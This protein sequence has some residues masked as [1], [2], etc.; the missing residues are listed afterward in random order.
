[1]TF[2]STL[3]NPRKKF[4]SKSDKK[5]S[6]IFLTKKQKFRKKKLRFSQFFFRN[7]ISMSKNIGSKIFGA[8]RHLSNEK[9]TLEVSILTKTCIFC[10]F[11]TNFAVVKFFCE[12]GPR[13]P[14]TTVDYLQNEGSGVAQN[15]SEPEI[16]PVLWGKSTFPL[17]VAYS[18]ETRRN[19]SKPL[20][21]IYCPPRQANRVYLVP[22]YSIHLG[23][24]LLTGFELR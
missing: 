2:L 11:L 21:I 9:F 18:I 4:S 24:L 6:L 3:E 10:W 15:P 5:S 22:F 7:E 16:W 14:V 12:T 1:M 20:P 23:G 13:W 19:T 17:E 8:V